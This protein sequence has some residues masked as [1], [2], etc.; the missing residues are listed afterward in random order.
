MSKI[1]ILVILP[2]TTGVGK[3]RMI[4]PFTYIQENY[5]DDFH[6]DLVTN[7]PDEDSVFND[8]DIIVAHSFIHSNAPMER[9]IKRV[10]WLKKQGKIVIIDFD[11]YWELDH[12]HPMFHYAKES[13]MAETKVKWLKSASYVTVTTPFFRNTIRLKYKLDNVY[14]FPNAIDETEK[15]FIP[16]PET[17]DRVRFGFLGGSSHLYDLELLTNG[18]QTTYNEYKDKCQFVLCGFDLRGKIRQMNKDT[19]EVKERDIVPEESVWTKYE[20]IFTDNYKVIDE[21]YNSILKLYKEETG[22]N[23]TNKPYRRVWTKPVNIYATNYNKF[24]VSLAPLVNSVFNNNKSQLKVVEAGFHKKALIAS[25]INPYT[26]DLISA[27]EKGGGYNDKG[28]ALLVD[29]MKNHK[30]WGQHMVRL[31]KNPNLIE[32]LGN[33]LY[34]T[35]KVDYSLKKVCADR[36]DFIKSIYK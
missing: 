11:D 28:N 26:I 18:I 20:K 24:D 4:S 8:H 31:I 36:V 10:E 16:N 34:E 2:D 33:K 23:D 9:N 30:Q 27:V 15:Q 6:I 7:I 19:G 32:D 3:F 29:P 14:V 22:Y 17:S 35:V 12:R 1:K 25:E 5:G 13:K 21:N